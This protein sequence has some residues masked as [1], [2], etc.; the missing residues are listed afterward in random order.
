MNEKYD[1]DQAAQYLGLKEGTLPIWRSTNRHP[2]PAYLKIGRKVVYLK[3]D[4]DAYLDAV[5]VTSEAV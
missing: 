5:R 4:L 2:Q 1:N 3:R